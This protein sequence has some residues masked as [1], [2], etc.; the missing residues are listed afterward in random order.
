LRGIHS[1]I[2]APIAHRPGMGADSRRASKISPSS[3]SNPKAYHWIFQKTVR[4]ERK[5]F[6]EY[7]SG[8][9]AGYRFRSGWRKM[10]S[11]AESEGRVKRLSSIHQK[12]LRSIVTNDQIYA[13]CPCAG[14]TRIH[15]QLFAALASIPP[16]RRP[17]PGPFFQDYIAMPRPNLKPSLHN[18]CPNVQ[19]RAERVVGR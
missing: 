15:P 17:V 13:A 12:S 2:Y 10:G 18:N 1:N 14:I 16:G 7:V 11:R 5:E 19:F 3:I 4:F 8:G 9:F 6:D